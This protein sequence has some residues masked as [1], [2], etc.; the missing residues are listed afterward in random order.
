MLARLW[1]LLYMAWTDNNNGRRRWSVSLAHVEGPL[2]AT[3]TIGKDHLQEDKERHEEAADIHGESSVARYPPAIPDSEKLLFPAILTEIVEEYDDR[4]S[5]R[6]Q[7]GGAEEDRAGVTG[8]VGLED[9]LLCRLCLDCPAVA[10][11]G[12]DTEEQGRPHRPS[13][14]FGDRDMEYPHCVNSHYDCD[15]CEE[16]Q[17]AP[18]D[19]KKAL[20]HDGIV[21]A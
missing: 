19:P 13:S 21:E 17:T 5:W 4:V 8:A 18:D 3:L 10:Y 1:V 12:Q 15:Q 2:T 7:P 9:V 20:S 6:R 14:R 16:Y 11:D